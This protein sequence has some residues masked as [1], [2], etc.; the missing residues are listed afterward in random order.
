[1]MSIATRS[2]ILLTCLWVRAYNIFIIAE[3]SFIIRYYTVQASYN[4]LVAGKGPVQIKLPITRIQ[5]LREVTGF[6][7]VG[8]ICII[9]FWYRDWSK[10][11]VQV[12]TLHTVQLFASTADNKACALSMDYH[13]VSLIATKCL[14]TKQEFDAPIVAQICGANKIDWLNAPKWPKKKN[15]WSPCTMKPRV[16]MNS[17]G[18]PLGTKLHT[19]IVGNICSVWNN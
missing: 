19:F 15:R 2:C 5:Y 9:H 6:R 12:K 1:M 4:T 3:P 18:E 7:S 16:S 14:Q 17:L 13:P 10:S 8:H 11:T